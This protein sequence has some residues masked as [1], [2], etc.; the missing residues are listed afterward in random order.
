MA[1]K[2]ITSDKLLKFCFII[3][4][5]AVVLTFIF[6]YYEKKKIVVLEFGTFAG[7]IYDV[8]D[9]QS[10]KALDKAIDKFEKLH[11]NIK[12]KYKSGILKSD[13]SERLS[14][15]IIK[16]NEP[17][18]FCV[19][20]GDFNTF[21]SIGILEKLDNFI[22]KDSSFDINKIYE[23][24]V[25]AGQSQGYQYALPKELDPEL[26]F[27]NK[28]LLEKEGIEVPSGNWNWQDFYNICKKITKDTD[29][30]G[31]LD[32]FGVVGFQ[33]QHAVYT[34][35]QQL[36]DLN[37]NSADFNKEGIIEAI[38]FITSL[39][40]L[41]QNYTVTLQDFDAGKVAF[42]PFLFSSY[43]AYKIYPYKVI[44]YGKFEWECIKLP[45]G[46]K[47]NNASQLNS[48]LIGMSSRSKHKKEAWEFLKFL[49]YNKDIQLDVFRYSYG[50]PVIKDIVGSIEAENE[51]L[52][53]S[54]GEKFFMDKKSLEEIVEQSLPTPRFHKYEEAMD[55]AD[56][57][58][59]QLINS[60]KDAE[61]T[62]A[63][64]NNKINNLLK[65]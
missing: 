61:G 16:G 31:R 57:E 44:R 26:M 49:T 1:N 14:Q 29:G 24:A 2:R 28:T 65:Q 4:L 12:I 10:Y 39:N 22:K 46:P 7:S 37:G 41:N 63:K 50:M 47:G 13:Y 6:I 25:Q 53:Y 45:R 11:P 3:A 35:G 34:N 58:I 48:F 30:D 15:S 8:P 52:K 43:R 9:W 62:I 18:V 23:N 17:D 59:Y 19:L 42:K 33:W 27:V 55:I 51:L 54:S 32:Q 64:L 5:I 36:F 40:K 21:T 60:G 20:P 56:K 38:S